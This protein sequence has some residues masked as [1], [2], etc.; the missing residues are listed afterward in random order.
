MD[1]GF[2]QFHDF[3]EIKKDFVKDMRK[4]DLGS[5]LK[6]HTQPF[7]FMHASHDEVVSIDNARAL[8]SAASQPKELVI[9]EDSTHSF[10]KPEDRQYLIETLLRFFRDSLRAAR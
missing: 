8:Y 4:H 10:L 2:H 9:I 1:K 7:L 3:D 5:A 6:H